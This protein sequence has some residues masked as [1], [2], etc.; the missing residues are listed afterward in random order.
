MLK[1]A[2]F[3]AALGKAPFDQ[4]HAREGFI[5]VTAESNKGIVHIHDQRPLVLQYD[6]VGE[7]LYEDKGA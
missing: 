6:S 3:F 2:T 7:W 1:P 5:I 4:D